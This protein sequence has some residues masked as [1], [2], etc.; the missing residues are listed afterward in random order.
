MKQLKST[1]IKNVEI[2]TAPGAKYNAEVNAVIR[3]KTLKTQG[4]GFSLMATSQTWRNNKWNNYDD[5]TLKYRTGGLEMF[6]NIGLDNG[7][8]SND[9]DIEQELHI[10]KDQFV[11]KAFI[12]VPTIL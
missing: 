7:H 12:P 1:D 9:Q 11:A 5:L 4:E 2:I 6:A 3:I 8:Y 10:K